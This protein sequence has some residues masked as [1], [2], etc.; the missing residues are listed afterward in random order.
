MKAVKN[1]GSQNPYLK[2]DCGETAES[3]Q[4]IYT[5]I[6]FAAENG[7]FN[8]FG[9]GGK[10]ICDYTD[11]NGELKKDQQVFMNGTAIMAENGKIYAFGNE[12]CT[13]ETKKWYSIDVYVNPDTNC[14]TVYVNGNLVLDNVA[15][16]STLQVQNQSWKLKGFV[17]LRLTALVPTD[18]E[19]VFYYD[20]ISYGIMNS[21]KVNPGLT[22]KSFDIKA[23]SI[24]LAGVV[25]SDEQVKNGLT[26]PSGAVLDCT[27][28]Y[29]RLENADKTSYVYY[30]TGGGKEYDFNDKTSIFSGST[31]TYADK[32]G[33]KAANDFAVTTTGTANAYPDEVAL[34]EGEKLVIETD[35]LAENVQSAH[36]FSFEPWFDGNPTNLFTIYD[37]QFKVTSKTP[38]EIVRVEPNKWYHM[39]VVYSYNSDEV[40]IYVNNK[41]YGT[42]KINNK[43]TT[44]KR[45]KYVGKSGV[46]VDNV[47]WYKGE[48]VPYSE[49]TIASGEKYCTSNGK[50][51]VYEKD[52]TVKALKEML[53]I[54]GSVYTDSTFK[55]EAADSNVVTDNMYVAVRTDTHIAYY[56]I[57]NAAT[58]SVKN[59]K[60]VCNDASSTVDGEGTLKNGKYTLSADFVGDKDGANYT[61][62]IVRYN[63]GRLY[64]VIK[65][66]V[67]VDSK[68]PYVQASVEFTYKGEQDTDQIKA[69]IWDEYMNP[70]S[71]AFSAKK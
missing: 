6:S 49:P 45:I 43:V 63:N 28:K 68:N 12:V 11:N 66:P 71:K 24:I 1:R 47:R 20:D 60:F 65:K 30:V 62:Y 38:K 2:K 25:T 50:L 59:V 33:G 7:D 13:F 10:L 21:I 54:N 70:A 53:N 34:A 64:D 56:A 48:Y 58:A 3:G 29:A 42:Y 16:K 57:V 27:M 39:A 51:L 69:F 17:D 44:F 37:G 15:I 5:G 23:N 46:Y 41:D 36:E 9:L 67:T 55:T 4:Y 35:I 52:M 32:I 18:K 61:M 14:E 40:K 26:V 31:V 19:N 8:N 22:S